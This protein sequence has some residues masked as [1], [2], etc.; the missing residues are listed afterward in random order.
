MKIISVEEVNSTM[1]IS[2]VRISGKIPSRKAFG[3]QHKS[4]DAH[5]ATYELSLLLKHFALRLPCLF[6]LY[7]FPR[8]LISRLNQQKFIMLNET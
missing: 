5:D 7:S 4:Q 3:Q 8:N 6:F 1:F 2:N